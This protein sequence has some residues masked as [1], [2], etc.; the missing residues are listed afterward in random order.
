MRAL[1]QEAP[2]TKRDEGRDERGSEED[3]E[4]EGKEELRKKYNSAVTERP[5][6]LRAGG[7]EHIEKHRHRQSAR[8]RE[9]RRRMRDECWRSGPS[10]FL[11]CCHQLS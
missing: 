7:R 4:V 1:K 2:E 3:K 9:R 6:R 5:E 10:I 11:F 8:E